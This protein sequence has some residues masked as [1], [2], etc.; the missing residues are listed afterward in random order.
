M[1]KA[2][3][4]ANAAT[5]IMPLVIME[6]PRFSR[7]RSMHSR[8]STAVCDG[9]HRFGEMA[10]RESA[11]PSAVPCVRLH[12]GGVPKSDASEAAAQSIA[13]VELVPSSSDPGLVDGIS[14][15]NANFPP[16]LVAAPQEERSDDRFHKHWR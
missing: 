14:R 8:Y 6:P 4:N 16:A 11:R 12:G 7:S 10:L 3:A 5:T 15:R 1:P 2:R 9:R 13:A